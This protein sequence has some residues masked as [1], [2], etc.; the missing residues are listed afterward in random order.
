MKSRKTFNVSYATGLLC[1][2]FLFIFCGQVRSADQDSSGSDSIWARV[3]EVEGGVESKISDEET[4]LLEPGGFLKVGQELSLRS[5]SSVTL[6][7][8]DSTVR[9]FDGPA[10]ITIKE[11]FPKTDGSVLA[12]LGSAIVRLLFIREEQRPEEV[13]APREVEDLEDQE[14]YLPL[15]VYPAPG[16]VVLE[17]PAKFEWRKIEGVPLYRVSVYSSNR[18]LWQWTTSDSHI[19]CP[20]EHCNFKYGKLYYWV[21]EGLIGDS[22]LRSKAGEFEVLP[23]DARSELYEALSDPNLSIL[24]KV[25]LCLN[26]NVYDK[27]LELANSHWDEGSFDRKAYLLRAEIKEKMGL[28][29]DASLDYRSASSFPAAD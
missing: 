7:M 4:R 10:T 16:S 2:S 24:I 21:V 5:E 11:D 29:E 15:L 26:L 9:K 20:A 1:L 22:A 12:R 28:F 13:L 19:D 25:R 23:Q 17:K 3:L 27:A 18:I 14:R 8:Q 6:V